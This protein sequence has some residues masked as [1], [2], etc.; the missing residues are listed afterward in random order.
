MYYRKPYY[1]SKFKCIADKCPATCCE[2]WEIVIDDKTMQKYNQLSNS[3]KE[4]VLAHVDIQEGV[5]KQCGDRCAFLNDRNLCD[6][7]TRLG[8]GAFCKTCRRYPRHFEEY[9][10]LVEA[11]LSMSC[12][13]A[14]KMIVT[15]PGRDRFVEYRNEKKSPHRDEVDEVLLAG[16]LEVREHMIDIISDRSIS[17][18]RRLKRVYQ[19][20]Y[21]VQKLIYNYE[22]LGKKV[23]MSKCASE[24]LSKMDLLTKKEANYEPKAADTINQN[25][26]K[27]ML[28]LLDVMSVLEN[29][30]SD[31]PMLM[32]ELKHTLYLDMTNE[33]YMAW[34]KEFEAY[35]QD[36][37]YEYEH[38]V[39]YF[40]YTYYL[41][42]VYDYN[43]HSMTKQAL[44]SYAIIRDFGLLSYI[45]NNKKFTEKEQIKICYTYSR[46][47]EHS[48]DNLMALEGLLVAH[49]ELSDE[50]IIRMI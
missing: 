3:D 15:N 29:I 18:K 43:V 49:P 14:A 39:N 6:L 7:Y 21:K 31:W 9:G 16:L 37:N 19:Y 11:A 44:I 45:K 35:M 50:N 24:F 27:S 5:F 40:I 48:D 8:E 23:K 34:S 25:R 36:R 2:G 26:Q 17:L 22:V 20:S 12:P 46:Q 4:Y 32:E 38:I 42:G 1:Y 41:G 30:N 28:A 47:I 10:N 13:V 33:E